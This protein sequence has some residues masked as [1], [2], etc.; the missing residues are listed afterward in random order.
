MQ[1]THSGPRP[2]AWVDPIGSNGPGPQLEAGLRPG[3]MPDPQK[4]PYLGYLVCTVCGCIGSN[5]EWTKVNQ[6][7]L[8]VQ[9]PPQP[10]GWCKAGLVQ[11][12]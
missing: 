10:I 3:P 8:T 6:L 7:N 11:G 5:C 4:G 9:A 2:T 1:P 12:V